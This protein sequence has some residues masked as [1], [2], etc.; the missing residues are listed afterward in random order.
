MAL[1]RF[2]LAFS[3]SHILIKEERGRESL[4]RSSFIINPRC[5]GD[6][7]PEARVPCVPEGAPLSPRGVRAFSVQRREAQ[8]TALLSPLEGREVKERWPSV[9]TGLA[10]PHSVPY[11]ATWGLLHFLWPQFPHP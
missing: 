9:Q 2:D 1:E 7:P 4:R 6:L 8:A 11:S 5:E 10:G 3:P